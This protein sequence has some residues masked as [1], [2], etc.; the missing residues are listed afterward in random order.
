MHVT[1]RVEIGSDTKA[2]VL[3]R[4]FRDGSSFSDALLFHSK[5]FCAWQRIA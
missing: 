4:I 3:L 1:G 5:G 2:A